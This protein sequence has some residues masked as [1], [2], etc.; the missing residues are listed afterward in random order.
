MNPTYVRIELAR[1]GRDI[2]N[3]MFTVGLPAVMY[4]LFGNMFGGGAE[5]AG[6]GN[7]KFYIMV[8]MAAYGAAVATTGIAGT[9]AT[10]NMLG[11]GRQIA[12]TPMK[13]SGFIQSKMA[14]ALTIAAAAA[15]AVFILGAATGAQADSWS[16]WVLS[17][18]VSVGG[19]AVFALY[20][21]GVGMSFKSETAISV[22]GGLLVFFAFFG[23][24]FM[25]LSGTMLDIARFTP[26]Y[27]FV[28]LARWP[29]LQGAV[30]TP[31][32]PA[33]SFWWLVANLVA[34]ALLF[35]ALALWALRKTRSRQ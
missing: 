34:W 21:M 18:A 8:S 13:P 9:A 6:G 5:Q 23:N 22:A 16:V 17:Y 20:G 24:V 26:M 2:G 31:G 7:V 32:A 28:G 4:L 3:L 25:P 29:L 14:V 30:A 1:Q 10:E 19:A 12:L 27:G 11:W 33:D 35:A 15:G